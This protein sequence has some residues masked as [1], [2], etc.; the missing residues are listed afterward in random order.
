[1]NLFIYLISLFLLINL[2]S[3]QSISKYDKLN[4]KNTSLLF[5]QHK[6]ISIKKIV[7]NKAI[8]KN[9]QIEKTSII[10][11]F[12]GFRIYINLFYIK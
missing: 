4:R 8:L 2:S 12:R 3:I 5:N 10:R 7:T 6:N 11:E 9:S 1:M